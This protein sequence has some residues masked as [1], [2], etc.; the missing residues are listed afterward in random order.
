MKHQQYDVDSLIAVVTS[1]FPNASQRVLGEV[2]SALNA[3]AAPTESDAWK[4]LGNRFFESAKEARENSEAFTYCLFGGVC[5]GR[6][7]DLAR[8]KNVAAGGQH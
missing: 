5:L 8:A 7:V 2:V 4:E 1:T 6:S 3:L